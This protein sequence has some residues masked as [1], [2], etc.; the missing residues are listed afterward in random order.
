MKKIK[1]CLEL[2][3]IIQTDKQRKKINLSENVNF[4]PSRNFP[5]SKKDW[6]ILHFVVFGL[7]WELKHKSKLFDIKKKLSANFLPFFATYNNSLSYL[8]H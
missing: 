5:N 2:F 6:L 4:V 3:Q 1:K 8:S 7:Q